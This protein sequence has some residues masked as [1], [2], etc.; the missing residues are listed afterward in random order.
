MAEAAKGIGGQVSDLAK[1]V[2]GVV[3][4][5]AEEAADQSL[6]KGAE[7]ASSVGQ[8]VDKLADRIDETSPTLSGHVRDAA[9]KVN[10]FAD[11]LDNKKVA[12]LVQSAADFGRAH[13]FVM[14][15]G[16]ALLGFALAR[17]MGSSVTSR[18]HDS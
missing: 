4:G 3:G 8:K 17:L 6:K 12:D 1:S 15:A 11:D 7:L 9:D 5:K 16:A 18:T 14:M 2:R 13:P 10:R